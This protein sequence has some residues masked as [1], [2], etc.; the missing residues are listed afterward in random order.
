MRVCPALHKSLPF[1]KDS[2][3]PEACSGW[4][5]LHIMGNGTCVSVLILCTWAAIN[6]PPYRIGDKTYKTRWLRSDGPPPT[7]FE[8]PKA[9]TMRLFWKPTISTISG[10]SFMKALTISSQ[11]IDRRIVHMIFWALRTRKQFATVFG[12]FCCA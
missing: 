11:A 2:K 3:R 1:P 9:M 10:L 8:T 12:N 4:N 7:P 6:V 5:L